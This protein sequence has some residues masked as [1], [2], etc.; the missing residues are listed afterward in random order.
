MTAKITLK[1]TDNK[2]LTIF[3]TDYSVDNTVVPEGHLR[4]VEM[5]FHLK[6]AP[7]FLSVMLKFKQFEG[8]S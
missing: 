4:I 6:T 1:N 7:C 5:V 8:Q 3:N 2:H